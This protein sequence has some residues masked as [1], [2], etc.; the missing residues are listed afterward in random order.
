MGSVASAKDQ[1]AVYLG[2]EWD[3]QTR[4]K[5]DGSVASAA[6]GEVV[7]PT[8]KTK[9]REKRKKKRKNEKNAR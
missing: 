6:T 4:G 9:K 8:K 5:H 3:D 1:Q 2:V 7:K